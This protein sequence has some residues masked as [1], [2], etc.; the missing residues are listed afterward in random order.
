ME[1]WSDSVP[2]LMQQSDSYLLTSNYEGWARVLVEAIVCDLPVVTTEV[3]C[4][5]EV[6]IHEKNGLV[7]PVGDYSQLVH[8]MVWISTDKELYEKLST[9]IQK[10]DKRS[11]PGTDIENYGKEW[12]K[13]LI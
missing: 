7:V 11:L 2:R 10:T 3:G 5:G 9:E 1:T 12:I 4:V 6:I 13:T 8:S